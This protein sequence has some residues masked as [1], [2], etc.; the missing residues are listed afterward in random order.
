MILLVFSSLVPL[1][2]GSCSLG[3]L[4]SPKYKTVCKVVY[5]TLYIESTGKVKILRI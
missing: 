5:R 1:T 4:E 3:L 2:E